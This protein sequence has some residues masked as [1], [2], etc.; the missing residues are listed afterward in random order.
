M[1]ERRPPNQPGPKD[2]NKD[3]TAPRPIEETKQS[4][5]MEANVTATDKAAGAALSRQVQAKLGQQLRTYYERLL[6]P[7]PDRF[8]D[9]LRQLDTPHSD[10]SGKDSE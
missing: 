8:V 10:K 9:L 2:E 5:P 4:G 1:N 7:T 6:E 3:T